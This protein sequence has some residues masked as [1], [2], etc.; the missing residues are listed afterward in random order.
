MV[1]KEDGGDYY[2]LIDCFCHVR[3]N[4]GD[5]AFHKKHFC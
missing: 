4:I 2:D 1:K 5:Y 3:R